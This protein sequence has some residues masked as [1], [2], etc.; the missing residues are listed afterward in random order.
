MKIEKC[1][2][3]GVISMIASSEK[4][5]HNRKKQRGDS[6]AEYAIIV[7]LM[8]MLVT[9]STVRFSNQI[10]A[11]FKSVNLALLTAISDGV[12]DARSSMEKP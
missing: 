9:V 6:L 10:G 5:I 11:V 7:G 8:T 4:A 12:H 1:R 2:F 3:C